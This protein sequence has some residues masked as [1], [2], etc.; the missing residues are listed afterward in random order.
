[1]EKW[2]ASNEKLLREK[3]D[4]SVPFGEEEKKSLESL[5]GGMPIFLQALVAVK[6]EKTIREDDS[7]MPSKQACLPV[8]IFSG[9]LLNSLDCT[10]SFSS[11]T[12]SSV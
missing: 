11:P 3:L 5:T 12:K 10:M 8:L 2:W 7:E 9:F 1:M 4:V 6:L